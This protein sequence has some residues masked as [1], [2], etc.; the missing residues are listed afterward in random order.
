MDDDVAAGTNRE[1]S[2][3]LSTSAHPDAVWRLW[4]DVSTWKDWDKGLKDA[5]LSG[6]FVKGAQGKI[7]PLSGPPARFDVT[8][9]DKEQGCAFETHLPFARLEVRRSF[10]SRDPVAFRHDVKFKGALAIVW[11]GLL[12]AGFRKALPPTMQALA[13]CAEQM[14]G[15]RQ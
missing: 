5:E 2:H 3:T 15:T 11:A 6:P 12:G 8:E 7:I 9:C 10:A 14:S 4:T 13:E 1:F